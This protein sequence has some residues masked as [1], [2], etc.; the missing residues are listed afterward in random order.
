M[1]TRSI[2]L[3]TQGRGIRVFGFSPGTIDTDM[4][5]KIRASGINSVSRIPR[6]QLSPV[7]HAVHGV[8]FLCSSDANDLIGQDVSLRND[9]FRERVGLEEVSRR[10]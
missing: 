4:Q 3:E 8:V 2:A 9:L 10:Q 1:L 7:E 6:D 5:A